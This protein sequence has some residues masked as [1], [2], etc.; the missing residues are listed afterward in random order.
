MIQTDCC[1]ACGRQIERNPATGCDNHHCPRPTRKRRQRKPQ[2]TASDRRDA[3]FSSRLSFGF[4][5]MN[6]MT[7]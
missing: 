2:A 4:F 5:L 1:V 3:S 7:R 6:L